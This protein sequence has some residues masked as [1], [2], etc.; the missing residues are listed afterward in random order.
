LKTWNLIATWTLW[1]PHGEYA[2]R[3]PTI[4]TC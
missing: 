4:V 1:T 2:T 3:N